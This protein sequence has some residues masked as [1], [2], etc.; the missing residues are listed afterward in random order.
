M[1]RWYQYKFYW[2]LAGRMWE[3]GH[4]EWLHSIVWSPNFYLKF[5][6]MTGSLMLRASKIAPEKQGVL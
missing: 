1:I 5:G 4:S 3:I 2:W 6:R